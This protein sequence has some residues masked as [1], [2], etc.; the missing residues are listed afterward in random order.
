MESSCIRHTDL[1]HTSRLYADFIYHYDRVSAFYPHRALDLKEYARIAGELRFPEDRRAALAAALRRTNGESRA[2]DLLELPDT[3]AIV[4][5]QQVGL[6]SGPAYTIY[7]ALTVARLAAHLNEQGINAVPI[8][9]LAT[10]DHDF[11]EVDHCWVFNAA[12][13]PVRLR[14]QEGGPPQVPVGGF[15]LKD[16]PLAALREA[17]GNL[18]FAEEVLSL[19]EESYVVGETMGGSF[20]RLLRRLL[21]GYGF[22]FVDPLDPAIRELAAPILSKAVD[23][24]PELM[25]ALL[26]RNKELEAAG[27]HAQVHLEPETSLVFLLEGERRLT[28][29]RRNGDFVARDRKFT[30]QELKDKADHLSPNALLRPIVQDYI[31]PTAAYAGGPAELAYFAQSSVI[32]EALLG[33][34]PVVLPRAGYTLLDERSRKLMSR[35][36][37]TLESALHGEDLLRHRIA[38]TLV[39]HGLQGRF[40]EASSAVSHHL[41]RLREG[42]AAFDPTLAAA[43]DKS[44]AKMLYQLSKVEGKTARASMKRDERAA[45]DASWLSGLLFPEKH[46]QERFYSILPFLAR[47][48]LDLVDRV[49]ENVHLECPDHVILTV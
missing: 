20:T 42:L 49:Y 37:L 32:Y 43:L 46:L 44:R 2:L 34:M 9:W 24:M 4:T 7:K 12:N 48:G 29:K 8:F 6:F 33:R 13:Q 21:T 27:Y 10:E 3:V 16:I 5:G 28:L 35:Y 1:P 15:R 23:A 39:P 17:L 22:L 30:A 31:M 25:P 47:H 26:A 40:G 14:L 45:E 11:A 38:Q 41:D 19:V 18:P 36:K